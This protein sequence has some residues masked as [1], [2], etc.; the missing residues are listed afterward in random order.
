MTIHKWC[1]LINLY[2]E[3][4]IYI[5]NNPNYNEEAV[6]APPTPVLLPVEEEGDVEEDVKGDVDEIAKDVED[7]DLAEE[8]KD[9]KV[10]DK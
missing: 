2:A 3:I 10:K 1:I 6:S 4:N 7:A 5:Y 8:V 9:L